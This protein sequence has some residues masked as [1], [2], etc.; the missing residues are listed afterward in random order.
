MPRVGNCSMRNAC[1]NGVTLIDAALECRKRGE[2][3]TDRPWWL[4][5][6]RTA[7]ASRNSVISVRQR[8][9]RERQAAN[10]QRRAC[11]RKPAEKVLV[12][13]A[14]PEAVLARDKLNVFRPLYSVQ[15]LRDLDSPLV[16]GYDVLT[17]NND[18]GV[19]EP[20]V[21]QMADNVGHKPDDAAGR[22]GLR[23]DA[24]P[25]VLRSGRHHVVRP[26]SGERLQREERQ[27]DAV[28]STAPSCPRAPFAGC[29]RS[30]PTSVPK[31]IVCTS[32]TS[33]RSSARITRLR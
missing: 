14:D 15:L 32:A 3:M 18:N 33:K 28:Q 29:R 4:A 24:S 10:A 26:A 22:F 12:S 1:R 21:E 23:F 5:E 30:K 13:S 8:V 25:G 7:C 17:Q 20:M 31:A 27:E 2:T 16:F 9:L 6:L 19:L 11:K